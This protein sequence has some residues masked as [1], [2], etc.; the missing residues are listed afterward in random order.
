M[1]ITISDPQLLAQLMSTDKVEIKDPSGRLIGV[2]VPD[3]LG[4]LPPGV[5]SPFSD[6]ELVEL[7]KQRGGRP[8]ADIMRDLEARG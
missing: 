5:K 3:G 8:L 1:S 6:E 4:R 2:F 7:R